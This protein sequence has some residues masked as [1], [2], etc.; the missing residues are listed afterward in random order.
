[1]VFVFRYGNQFLRLL[2]LDLFEALLRLGI[3]LVAEKVK[4]KLNG[5]RIRREIALTFTAE[6]LEAEFQDIGFEFGNL[7]VFQTEKIHEFLP[8]RGIPDMYA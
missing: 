7:A 8:S 4:S 5:V 3:L 6:E 1:M 2:F